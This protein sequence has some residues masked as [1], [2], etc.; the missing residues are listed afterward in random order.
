[1]SRPPKPDNEEERLAALHSVDILDSAPERA[2]DD[3]VRIAAA[4]CGVPMAAV[5]LIDRDRQW[6][7]ARVGMDLSLIHI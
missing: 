4:I 5:T 7:K 3:L 6:F 2:F 1:M